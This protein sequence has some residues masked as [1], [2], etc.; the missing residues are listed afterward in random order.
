[1]AVLDEELMDLNEEVAMVAEM[2][3]SEALGLSSLA[4]AK[5]HPDWSDWEYALAEELTTLRESGTWEIEPP[6]GANIVRSKWVFKAKKDVDGNIARKKARLV[7]QGFL[8]IPGINYFDTYAPVAGLTLIQTI[9]VL[10][11]QN[12]MQF[13]QIDIKGAYLNGELNNDKVIYMCQPPDYALKEHPANYI[14]QLRKT[15]YK[16]KQRSEEHTSELQSPC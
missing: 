10:A 13:H 9:L 3:K 11:A 2:A 1:M 15:L 16:L 8:Q 14:C 12:D 7:A 6:P 4:E 5:H